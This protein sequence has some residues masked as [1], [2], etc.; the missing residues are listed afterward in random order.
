MLRWF[1]C[2]ASRGL[3]AKRSDSREFAGEC[4]A[5]KSFSVSACLTVLFSVSLPLISYAETHCIGNTD[6]I[7]L[8]YKGPTNVLCSH[9]LALRYEEKLICTTGRYTNQGWDIWCRN[10]DNLCNVSKDDICDTNQLSQWHDFEHCT[11]VG[12]VG[13]NWVPPPDALK[14]AEDAEHHHH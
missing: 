11:L 12:N 2:K 3:N 7:C 10:S 4:M 9:V 8:I 1:G 5:R 13:P 6:K 14:A